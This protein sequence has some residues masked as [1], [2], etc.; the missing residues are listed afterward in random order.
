MLVVED[1]ANY[2]HIIANILYYNSL[3]QQYLFRHMY[4][5]KVPHNNIDTV[6]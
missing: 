1:W 6:K 2:N 5:T 4:K 3:T